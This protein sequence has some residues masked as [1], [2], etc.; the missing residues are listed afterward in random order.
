MA[1]VTKVKF[2]HY[3]PGNTLGVQESQPRLSWK[4]VNAPS[5]FQQAGYE[6]E[7]SNQRHGVWTLSSSVQRTSRES[8]LVPWPFDPLASREEISIRVRIWDD[9]LTS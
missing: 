6:V 2:E 8:T 9:V 7:L 4:I 5:G 3:Q 1:S